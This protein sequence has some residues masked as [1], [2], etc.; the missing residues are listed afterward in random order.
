MDASDNSP[1]VPT[2]T[3]PS[4]AGIFGRWD[5]GIRLQSVTDGLTH[6]ILA[7]ETIASHCKYQCAHCPNFPI[8]PTNT[9]LNNFVHTPQ[10]L[11]ANGCHSVTGNPEEGGYCD[12]CGYKSRHPGDFCYIRLRHNSRHPLDYQLQNGIHCPVSFGACLRNY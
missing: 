12:A 9:P 10:N 4:F 6:T 1:H 11:P 8:S 5:K 7:G 2:G 3:I